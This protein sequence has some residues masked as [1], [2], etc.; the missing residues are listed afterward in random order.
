MMV[1]H[2]T[3]KWEVSMVRAPR[4]C[5]LSFEWEYELHDNKSSNSTGEMLACEY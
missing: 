5:P 4:V 3:S 2:T 1:Q